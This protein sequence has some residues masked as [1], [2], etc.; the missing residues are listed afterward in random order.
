MNVN[1]RVVSGNAGVQNLVS[2]ILLLRIL[3]KPYVHIV[4]ASR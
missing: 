1:N 3:C 4:G 2:A